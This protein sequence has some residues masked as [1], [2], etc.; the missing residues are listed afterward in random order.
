MSDET[1]R[2]FKPSR[3]PKRGRQ[4]A[5]LKA[6]L[7]AVCLVALGLTVG[8]GKKSDPQAPGSNPTYPKTYPTS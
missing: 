7:A 8:C 3:G 5:A 6:G 4:G 2:D 1:A